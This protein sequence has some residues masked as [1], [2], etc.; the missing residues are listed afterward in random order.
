MSDDD[1]E[2]LRETLGV[3]GDPALMRQVRRSLD[4]FAKGRAGATFETVF[5]EPLS[6]SSRKPRQAG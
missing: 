6:A 2:R 1:C 5:G 4:Y 3:L